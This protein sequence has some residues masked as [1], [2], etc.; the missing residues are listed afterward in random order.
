MFFVGCERNSS[1]TDTGSPSK[2]STK[3]TKEQT[4]V[5]PLLLPT[6]LF[7]DHEVFAFEVTG[8]PATF[9]V[10]AHWS[11]DRAGVNL[12]DETLIYS[13]KVSAES[14][15]G[16]ESEETGTVVVLLPNK[17]TGTIELYFRGGKT[18]GA[19]RVETLQRILPKEASDMRATGSRGTSP[20]TLSSFSSGKPAPIQIG[21]EGDVIFTHDQEFE[22]GN[23]TAFVIYTLTATPTESNP[24][25]SAQ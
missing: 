25:T 10:E 1:E 18:L 20:A 23:K 13:A 12:S 6:T 14:S 11:S 9:T 22:S 17:P 5:T 15:N 4:T 3:D 2:S 7:F 8:R 21:D 16:F 19:K 24:A